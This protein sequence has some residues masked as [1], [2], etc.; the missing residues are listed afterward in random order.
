VVKV[1]DFGLAKVV[2]SGQGLAAAGLTE[3]GA[4]LGTPAYMRP[5]QCL[6]R[7]LERRSDVYAIGCIMYEALL[8]EKP[9]TGETPFDCMLKHLNE[10][11]MAFPNQ[12]SP[13]SVPPSL[14]RYRFSF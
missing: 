4:T 3:T 13:V 10:P 2:E 8:G 14:N 7:L 12:H 9:F 1:V 6:G 11:P 5:E